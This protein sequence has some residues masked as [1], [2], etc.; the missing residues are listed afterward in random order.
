MSSVVHQMTEFIHYDQ[1]LFLC[2]LQIEQELGRLLLVENHTRMNGRWP[3]E[4]LDYSYQVSLFLG[5]HI[6]FVFIKSI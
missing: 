2:I 5:H 4:V 1:K 6:E 3:S